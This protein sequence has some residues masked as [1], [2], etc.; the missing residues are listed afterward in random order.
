[1]DSLEVV[2]VVSMINRLKCYETH[3]F[4][5]P[6][7]QVV[8]IFKERDDCLACGMVLLPYDFNDSTQKVEGINAFQICIEFWGEIIIYLLK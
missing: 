2:Y 5:K 8:N 3:Y 6:G 4:Q 7:A 1:M